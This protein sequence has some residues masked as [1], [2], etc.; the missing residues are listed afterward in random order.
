MA[1]RKL[2]GILTALVF[3]SGLT[4]GYIQGNTHRREQPSQHTLTNCYDNSAVADYFEAYHENET[5]LIQRLAKSNTE[6]ID[7][8]IESQICISYMKQCFNILGRSHKALEHCIA[9]DMTTLD[10]LDQGLFQ[11]EIETFSPVSFN[12]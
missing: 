2:E 4:M 1:R 3:I 6:H 10:E 7:C 5:K 11:Y 12:N 8:E 9:E